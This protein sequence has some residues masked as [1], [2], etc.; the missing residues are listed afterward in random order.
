[1]RI[2]PAFLFTEK[3]K[4]PCHYFESFEFILFIP[5]LI[6]VNL[7]RFKTAFTAFNFTVNL[8]LILLQTPEYLNARPDLLIDKVILIRDFHLCG[9]NY[10]ELN[11]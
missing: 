9:G 6:N 3:V 2:L 11:F 1:M 5:I 4:S 7:M 10:S 8:F